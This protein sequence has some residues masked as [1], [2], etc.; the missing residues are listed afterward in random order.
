MIVLPESAIAGAALLDVA[1]YPWPSALATSWS[2]SSKP[3]ISGVWML[4]HQALM[5]IR[6]FAHGSMETP[7]AEESQV[8][9]AMKHAAGLAPVE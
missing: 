1:Y 5:Q 4:V 9:E 3:V 8:L 2:G 6:L 7:L